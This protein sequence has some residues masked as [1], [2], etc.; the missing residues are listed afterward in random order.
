M[1]VEVNMNF[2]VIATFKMNGKDK[3]GDVKQFLH[4][5]TG[6]LPYLIELK[7][8][9]VTEG[10]SQYTTVQDD[11]CLETLTD[12][13]VLR[14]DMGTPSGD[15]EMFKLVEQVRFKWDEVKQST[16]TFSID[17]GEGAIVT[18]QGAF[19]TCQNL[20]QD[21]TKKGYNDAGIAEP[22]VAAAAVEEPPLV[23][24]VLPDNFDALTCS[25]KLG[26]LQA[27]LDYYNLM[28]KGVKSQMSYVRKEQRGQEI[29]INVAQM[30]GETTQ[31]N[32]KPKQTIGMVKTILSDAGVRGKFDLI[33]NAEVMKTNRTI[34]GYKI[35][36]GDT[37]MLVMRFFEVGDT[38]YTVKIDIVGT[39]ERLDFQYSRVTRFNDLFYFLNRMGYNT[40]NVADDPMYIIKGET[41]STA[42]GHEFLLEWC[43]RGREG[44]SLQ[45]V[46]VQRGGGLP[47]ITKKEAYD[48]KKGQVTMKANAMSSD[49]F[50]DASNHVKSAHLV[51]KVLYDKM[52][53]SPTIAFAELLQKLPDDIVGTQD[54][55]PL[56][57]CLKGG[58]RSNDRLEHFVE[59]LTK[60]LLPQVWDMVQESQGL[61]ESSN[62]TIEMLMVHLFMK[63]GADTWQWAKIKAL[64]VDEIKY[65]ARAS[66]VVDA[67]SKMQIG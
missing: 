63:D 45:L 26:H 9:V 40:G 36:D 16:E 38:I 39:D 62:L 2:L 64:V 33:Y 15:K 30:S 41:G 4:Q 21:D 54:K 42:G 10:V 5:V 17:I 52:E 46:P 35:A 57:D 53:N 65:R 1:R 60:A 44:Y 23:L 32:V 20:W 49:I 24:P 8:Y 7:C 58:T 48:K 14:M 67:M 12:R 28:V 3:A 66:N 34:S 43:G 19:I 50:A 25:E 6:V 22:P 59:H 11:T 13:E 18:K 27:Q 47:R 61:I 51:L 55:S 29:V 37:I 56:L 31:H